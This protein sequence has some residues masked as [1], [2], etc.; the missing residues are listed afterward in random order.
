V[1]GAPTRV[2]GPPRRPGT[3]AVRIDGSHLQGRA[4][5]LR[6]RDLPAQALVDAV[7]VASTPGPVPVS[8][9]GIHVDCDP[10][11]LVHGHVRQI[12]PESFDLY[13]A[14]VA[15]ARSH[16][17]VVAATR[18][19]EHARTALAAV[20]QRTVDVDRTA[21]KRRAAE[22]GRAEDRLGERVATLRGR[23]DARRELGADT[24]VVETELAEAVAELT[25]AETERIAAEQ[26]L[27]QIER[28]VRSER[29]AR[30]RRLRLA[31]RVDNLRRRVRRDLVTSVYDDFERAVDALPGETD[32]GTRPSEYAGDRTTAALAVVR[33]ARLRAPV[34]LSVEPFGSP[35]ETATW[36][37]APV[38]QLRSPGSS[39]TERR[40]EDV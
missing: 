40:P 15:A 17:T 39:Y 5:D 20:K 16:G 7:R 10:A 26:R 1:T 32:P 36:L 9:P 11:G 35:A 13:D 22:T 3:I 27:A 34:V 4:L 6:E 25:E 21:A 12:P 14:L 31:D 37:D 24:T 2:A 8:E 33:V 29:D 18:R 38:I 23:L 28:A 19:L 30:Q